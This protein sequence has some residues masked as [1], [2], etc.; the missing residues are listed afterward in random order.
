MLHQ[1]SPWRSNN[2]ARVQIWF[3][4]AKFTPNEKER[5]TSKKMLELSKMISQ[6]HNL[7]QKA[8][9]DLAKSGETF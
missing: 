1:V 9:F 5:D 7:Q 3:H 8:D 4:E 2:L 6:Q